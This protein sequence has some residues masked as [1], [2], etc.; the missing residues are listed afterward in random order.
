VPT[1]AVT[2]GALTVTG[3]T[4]V[5]A[6]RI[7]PGAGSLSLSGQLPSI[8]RFTTITGS[9]YDAA[10]GAK[11]TLGRLYLKPNN[12]LRNGNN[13]I[14]PK[15]VTYD[16]PGSGNLSLALAPSTDGITYTVEFDPTPADTTIPFRIKPGYFSDQWLVPVATSAD[17]ATL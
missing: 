6:R 14:A 10:T 13:V 12:F 5:L 4:S 16:I 3:T 9:I 1:I 17:I 15:T 11:R 2:N 8:T 7:F